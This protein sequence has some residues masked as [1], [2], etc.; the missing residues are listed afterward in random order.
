MI[1]HNFNSLCKQ[2]EP[3]YYDF[4][5]GESDEPVPEFI[6]KHIKQC[7]YCGEKIK[8]LEDIISEVVNYSDLKQKQVDLTAIAWLKLHFAYVGKQVTCKAVKPFL[9]GF[10]EPALDIKIPTPITVHLDNCWQCSKDL[11]TI[12]D[13]N[14]T[15]KQLY[16]LSQLFAEEDDRKD[17]NCSKAQ[18]AVPVVV[19]MLFCGANAETLNHLCSCSDCRKVLYNRRE[20]V[21]NEALSNQSGQGDF[22][23]EEVSISD[24]FDYTV[25]YGID[26]AD[27]QYAKFRQSLTC[28]IRSCPVCLSKMQKLHSTVYNIIDRTESEVVTVYHIDES[29]KSE[30]IE[31]SDNIY[32]G[33]PIKVEVTNR[34]NRAKT[35][36]P[37]STTKIA[38]KQKTS[39]KIRPLYKIAA[40]AAAVILIATVLFLNIPTAKAV[41]LERIYKAIEKIKNIHISSFVPDRKEPVQ[42]QWVSRVLNISILKTQKESVLWD[43]TNKIKKV[44]HPDDNPIE[45]TTLS[46]ET[47]PQIKSIIIGSLGLVP[48]QTMSE[49]PNDARWSR[50]DDKYQEI[51]D[52]IEVYDLMWIKK[53]FDGSKVFWKWRVF[54]DAKTTLPRR[55]E[56][57]QKSSIDNEYILKSISII[58][59]LDDRGMQEAIKKESF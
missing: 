18:A 19:S 8:R 40:S 52:G 58:K 42:E 54:V 49:I 46:S 50:V 2:A 33:F 37:T 11:K 9:P 23:C 44:K 28:H 56:W 36:Q 27:D 13:L 1:A 32:A 26:P 34:E 41:T 16:R 47:I 21:R 43:I 20:T 31:T 12:H 39:V 30:T 35:E 55:V 53:A 59:Y 3:Y 7:R 38:S 6:I 14:L 10:L 4:L 45:T 25:P 22:P 15:Q 51:A 17:I 24:I 29:A 57:Y 48:F 5:C